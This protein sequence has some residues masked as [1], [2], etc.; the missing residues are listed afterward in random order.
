[1][2]IYWKIFADMIKK[3]R[4]K[5]G[6]RPTAQKIGIAPSTLFRIENHNI[7]T[8]D[9]FLKLCIWLQMK[10]WAVLESLFR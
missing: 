7:P 10:P 4:G 9:T 2:N 8:M 5:E 6:L 1:M 3:K